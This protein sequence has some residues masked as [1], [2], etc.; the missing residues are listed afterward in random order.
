MTDKA[1]TFQGSR[2]YTA[3]V[4][5]ERG[6][7]DVVQTFGKYFGRLASVTV[8]EPDGK[9]IAMHPSPEPLEEEIVQQ[10]NTLLA[11]ASQLED[12]KKDKEKVI[13]A[14]VKAFEKLVKHLSAP[15]DATSVYVNGVIVRRSQLLEPMAIAYPVTKEIDTVNQAGGGE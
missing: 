15:E 5:Q 7:F 6:L 14:G 4:L 2:Q 11:D 10:F 3:Q 13:Y 9:V 12:Q 1:P 8:M